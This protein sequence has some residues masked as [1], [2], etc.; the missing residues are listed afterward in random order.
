[1]KRISRLRL[2]NRIRP[3]D[4]ERRWYAIVWGP[5]LWDTWAVRLVWGRLGT[6]RSQQQIREFDTSES[7]AA[8]AEAQV[9]RRLKRGYRLVFEV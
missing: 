2:F 9:E 8:E 4:N 3:K 6:G 5:T 7:A 1:V